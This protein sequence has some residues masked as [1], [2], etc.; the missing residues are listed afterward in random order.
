MFKITL[1]G[2]QYMLGRYWH[3]FLFVVRF[4]WLSARLLLQIA[5]TEHCLGP[6]RALLSQQILQ[7]DLT[8]VWRPRL[9]CN[10]TDTNITPISKGLSL[11]LIFYQIP[12]SCPGR[13]LVH[14]TRPNRTRCCWGGS[15]TTWRREAAR[16]RVSWRGR[17]TPSWRMFRW[18]ENPRFDPRYDFNWL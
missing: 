1:D 2:S 12:N 16:W 14:H 5:E 9:T 3:I 8:P 13:C 17:L 11:H 10:I 4:V 6:H 15:S 7:S 18:N